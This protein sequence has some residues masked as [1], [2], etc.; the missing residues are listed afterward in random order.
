MY[1]STTLSFSTMRGSLFMSAS[2]F[3][4]EDTL[5]NSSS[6]SLAACFASSASLL[7]A[8]SSSSSCRT[9]ASISLPALLRLAIS[10]SAAS[11]T[12]LTPASPPFCASFSFAAIPSSCCFMLETWRACDSLTA[13]SSNPS[14]CASSSAVRARAVR[15][16]TDSESSETSALRLAVTASPPLL[17]STISSSLCWSTFFWMLYL[18]IHS[19]LSWTADFLVSSSS[20]CTSA[21]ALLLD[22]SS[23]LSREIWSALGPAMFLRRWSSSVSDSIFSSP[24]DT[25]AL[26]WI[27]STSLSL[28][29]VLTSCAS[30]RCTRCCSRSSSIRVSA[31]VACLVMFSVSTSVLCAIVSSI[32]VNKLCSLVSSSS[33]LLCHRF[34]SSCIFAS[35]SRRSTAD[36]ESSLAWLFTLSKLS[37]M[38]RSSSSYDFLS[39]W[40]RSSHCSLCDMAMALR[41]SSLEMI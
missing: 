12:D 39:C 41:A 1:F 30:S 16:S 18:R 27:S 9:L 20:A 29:S 34:L 26:Q 13:W 32:C 7:T 40:R 15:V 33:N 38:C 24:S 11:C 25:S 19:S 21:S 23:F 22:S 3:A 37:S 10:L 5:W 6:F 2:C 14:L 4:S 8:A 36:E 17:S 31:S 35:R 28:S